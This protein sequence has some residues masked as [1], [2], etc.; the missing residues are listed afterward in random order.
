MTSGDTSKYYKSK[1]H[2]LTKNKRYDNKDDVEMGRL[3]HKNIM[4]QRLKRVNEWW[5]KQKVHENKYRE[6]R[7]KERIVKNW[8]QSTDDF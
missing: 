3:C 1:R 5:F 4:K 2:R 6:G 8:I 7:V